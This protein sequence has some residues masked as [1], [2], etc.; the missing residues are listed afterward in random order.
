MRDYGAMHE[1]MGRGSGFPAE[2]VLSSLVMVAMTSGSSPPTR[3]ACGNQPPSTRV[4]Q[5]PGQGT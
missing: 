3:A 4:A 1:V 2:A 5:R